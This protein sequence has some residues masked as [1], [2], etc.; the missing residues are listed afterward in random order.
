LHSDP[1]GIV[2]RATAAIVPT[3]DAVAWHT[4][5]VVNVHDLLIKKPLMAGQVVHCLTAEVI[6]TDLQSRVLVA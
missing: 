6:L 5:S 3:A 1:I 2:I 4:V